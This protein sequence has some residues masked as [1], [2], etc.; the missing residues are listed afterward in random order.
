VLIIEISCFTN[1]GCVCRRKLSPPAAVDPQQ[2]HRSSSSPEQLDEQQQQQ[3]QQEQTVPQKQ[4]DLVIPIAVSNAPSSGPC[5]SDVYVAP[6]LISKTPSKT[7]C[8][9]KQQVARN[10]HLPCSPALEGRKTPVAVCVSR[11]HTCAQA[12]LLYPGNSMHEWLA[13]VKHSALITSCMFSC[14]YWFRLCES[15]F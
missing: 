1:A 5:K 10:L 12:N 15:Q 13:E 14:H 4:R 3:Q 2:Q 11:T 7:D 6:A 9:P 8:S